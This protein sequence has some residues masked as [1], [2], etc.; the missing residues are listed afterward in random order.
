MVGIKK[1]FDYGED[2]LC[3]NPD[4]TFLHSGIVL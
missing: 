2:I 4:I 1:L 3:S